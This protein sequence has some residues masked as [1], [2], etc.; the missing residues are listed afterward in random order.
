MLLAPIRLLH[1]GM[2]L[3]QSDCCIRVCI[4][5]QSYHSFLA[6]DVMESGGSAQRMTYTINFGLILISVNKIFFFFLSLKV[7]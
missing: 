4:S 5:C 6:N 7:K 2:Y 1:R 3:A